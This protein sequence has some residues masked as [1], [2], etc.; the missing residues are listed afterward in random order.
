MSCII[1]ADVVCDSVSP[2]NVRLTTMAI[3]YPRVIHSE[4]MTHRMFSR[5]AASSRAIPISRMIQMVEE[6]PYVP[7][8]WGLNGKGMQDHGEMS[9]LGKRRAEKLWRDACDSAVWHA[10][11]YV[12]CNEVPHKQIV[13]R[14]LEPYMH[15]TTLVTSTYWDNW[16]WLRNHDAADPVIQR[17]AHEMLETYNESVPDQR[18]YGEYHM[19]YIRVEDIDNAAEWNLTKMRAGEEINDLDYLEARV[20][21][22]VLKMS[23]ARCARVSY[24]NHDKLIPSIG[25]EMAVFDK[26]MAS[27][28]LHA[29]PTEHQATPDHFITRVVDGVAGEYWA[30]PQEHGNLVGWKQYRKGFMGET[31]DQ[32]L[33]TFI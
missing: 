7:F 11:K 31:K 9:E 5:N 20:T 6:N 28:R 26:L 17:L 24:L 8:R 19:P 32:S 1:T 3:T 2:D 4:F 16:F 30:T 18:D 27:D 13:N 22:T 25:E 29:S 14:L 12:E 21:A 23:A 33:R 15:M 10:K